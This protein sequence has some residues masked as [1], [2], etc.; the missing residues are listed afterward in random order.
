MLKF[1]IGEVRAEIWFSPSFNIK[2]TD[3]RIELML[4]NQSLE[5]YDPVS[6]K[7][8]M[9]KAT[10]SL[11][12]AHLLLETYK[13]LVPE[14]NIQIHEAPQPVSSTEFGTSEAPALD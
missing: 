6:K 3:K 10:R 12:D 8:R 4:R 9:V 14:A 1:S 7:V 11:E 5:C 2:C 13:V